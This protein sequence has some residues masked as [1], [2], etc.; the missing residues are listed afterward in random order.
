MVQARLPSCHPEAVG[1]YNSGAAPNRAARRDHTC[2]K[3]NHVNYSTKRWAKNSIKRTDHMWCDKVALLA[4][5]GYDLDV[6]YRY[7]IHACVARVVHGWRESQAV[8]CE[9]VG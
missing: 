2:G 1:C 8:Q 6:G 9:A 3:T 4:V 5:G 7:T